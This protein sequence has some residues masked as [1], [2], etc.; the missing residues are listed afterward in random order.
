MNASNNI[1]YFIYL[2]QWQYYNVRRKRKSEIQDGSR[3]NRKYLHL[4][5]DQTAII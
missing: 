2:I 4:C 5:L 3:Q 1:R